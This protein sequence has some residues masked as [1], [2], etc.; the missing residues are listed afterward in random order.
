MPGKSTS[1]DE[2]SC[3]EAA[4]LQHSALHNRKVG[5]EKSR[6][7]R[8]VAWSRVATITAFK[9]GTLSYCTYGTALEP[10]QGNARWAL[11]TSTSTTM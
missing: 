1:D 8:G 10:Q 11:G 2:T 4:S 6:R 9:V 5:G 3:V 7:H